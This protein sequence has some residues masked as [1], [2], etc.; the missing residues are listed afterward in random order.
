LFWGCPPFYTEEK[1]LAAKFEFGGSFGMSLEVDCHEV[2]VASYLE[3]LVTFGMSLEGV[4]H[5]LFI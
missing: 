5:E 3:L 4:F 2:E 1:I